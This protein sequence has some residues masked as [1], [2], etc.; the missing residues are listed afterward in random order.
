MTASNLSMSPAEISLVSL[1]RNLRYSG[2][3]SKAGLAALFLG[4]L[5]TACG[6]APRQGTSAREG[7][8]AVGDAALYYREIGRGLPII[9]LHGGPDFDQSY[10]LPEMDRLADTYHLIYY[11]Q[12]GRGRSAV[13]VRPAEVSLASDIADI[14][15]VREYFHLDRVVLMGHSWG[16]E[17]A[18][19][20]ALQHPQRVSR[21]ILLNP[22]PGSAADLKLF[23]EYYVKVLG[24]DLARQKAISASAAYQKADPS[25]VTARYRIH[26]RPAIV[27]SED[28][29]K[30]MTRMAA[31]F[32]RQGSEG[33]L[34]ARAVEDRLTAD[35][36]DLPGY[37]LLPKLHTLNVPM[38][39]VASDHD[40]I[41][42]SVAEHIAQVS[43]GAHLSILEN[44]GH[45]S[46]LECPEKL[47]IVIDNFVGAEK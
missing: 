34:K 44:C 5:V 7:R 12:R 8:I 37:D 31:A 24:T 19:E 3:Q 9:V 47:R 16:T 26:F 14:D 22:V 46:Y 13:G 23:R 32:A 29:E 28:Y 25:A 6:A 10:L 38:L 43:P 20:Y 4:L 45:F 40:F 15:A 33:I 18:L 30:L 42:P 1:Y 17:L 36:W 21:L 11:D 35:S 2:G 41:P 27:R 39:V